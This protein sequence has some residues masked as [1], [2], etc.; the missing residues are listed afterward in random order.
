M[1][2]PTIRYARTADGVHIAYLTVGSGPQDLLFIPEWVTHCEVSW[3]H[4]LMGA[5]PTRFSAI[6]RLI[7]FDKRGVG[8]SDRV[9][10]AE[11]PSLETWLDDVRAVLDA[12]G[13]DRPVVLGMGHGGQ[14][15]M[16]LAAVE[17]ERVGGL[18][19]VNAYARLSRAH[20]YP[21]GY[22]PKVQD[23]VVAQTEEHW[24]TTGW[25]LDNLGPTLARD[26]TARKWWCRMERMSCSPGT[27][28]ALQRATFEQDVRHVLSS[29]HVPPLVMHVVGDRHVVVEHGRYLAEHI[30]GARYLELPGESHW[31]WIGPAKE[32]F[33]R[34]LAEFMGAMPEAMETDRVLTT[35]CFSDIVDSTARARE[36]GDQEWHR[37][38]DRLEELVQRQVGRFRGEV[39]KSTGDGHLIRFDG[40]GRAVNCARYIVEGARGLGLTMRAGVHTGEVE[41]RGKDIAGIAVHVAQRVQ[42]LAGDDEVLV[43]RTVV[44]LVAGSGLSLESRGEYELKGIPGRFE[45]FAAVQ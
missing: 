22:P 14:L 35:V 18:V 4:P 26:E 10:A 24:G 32:P 39:I 15:A 23:W 29:I 21:F 2:N 1:E 44:D 8:L 42:S 3:E 43:S 31:Y 20:D 28:A 30:P 27:A 11:V 36:V 12:T 45:L 7:T 41:V 38:L 40:P 37:V 16:L 33:A 5:L 17:P 13:S 34:A 25:M 9:S 6:A 19:L